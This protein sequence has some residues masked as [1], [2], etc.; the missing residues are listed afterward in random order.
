VEKLI[1]VS[2]CSIDVVAF[3]KMLIAWGK[4]HFRPFPWRSTED[5]YHILI[6]EV[7]L[8]RTRAIQV[9]P[10]YSRFIERYPDIFTL[11]GANRRELHENLSSL[12]LRWRIDLLQQMAVSLMTMFG[13]EVPRE[14]NELVSLP[15][16]NDYIAS[17]VRCFAWNLPEALIDTN[18][19]RIAGRLCGLEVKESSRRNRQFR[20]I[21]QAMVDPERPREYNYALLDLANQVCAKRKPGCEECP[22]FGY[23]KHETV[24]LAKQVA[25]II[26]T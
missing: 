5:P 13:R 24:L 1:K 8:H 7:M 23:C 14:K 4:E 11:S 17:A 9:V 25:G 2:E 18:T 3:R 20:E 19:V 22:V 15:G 6:A 16:V 26:L 12:G 10:V 21:L